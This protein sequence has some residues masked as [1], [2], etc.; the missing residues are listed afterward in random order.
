MGPPYKKPLIE[1]LAA[2]A[3]KAENPQ[4]YNDDM[5]PTMVDHDQGGDADWIM[6]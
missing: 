3:T 1:R 6:G 2:T 5:F 4:D